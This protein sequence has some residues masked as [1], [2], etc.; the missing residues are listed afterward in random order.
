MKKSNLF[1]NKTN[2]D[3]I[4]TE[5]Y[6]FY[7]CEDALSKHSSMEF[8]DLYNLVS[9]FYIDSKINF[10]AFKNLISKNF[11]MKRTRVFPNNNLYFDDNVL[12]KVEDKIN[13]INSDNDE[14]EISYF[15]S[16]PLLLNKLDKYNIRYVKD[17]KK[18][19]AKTLLNG[20]GV[21]I[22]LFETLEKIQLPY[23]DYCRSYVQAAIA[24]V[25]DERTSQIL[26]ERNGYFL[27][28]QK[29]LEEVG[30][31]FGITRER[32]RQIEKKGLEKLELVS[33][34]VSVEINYIFKKLFESFDYEFVSSD[35]LLNYLDN[36]AL[37][38]SFMLIL[39]S[40]AV[41]YVYD[42]KYC[43]IYN[44]NL[45]KIEDV[46]KIILNKF[47]DFIPAEIYDSCSKL[48]KI[49]INQNYSLLRNK[50]IYKKKSL[51]LSAL[52][53]E[54]IAEAFPN[55]YRY[56]NE[57][58]YELFKK[59]YKE[60]F[61]DESEALSFVSLRGLL[62]RGEFCQID[63]GKV[64]ARR[65]AVKIDD[66][67]IAEI[68]NYISSFEDVAYY[69][70]VYEKFKKQLIGYGVLN[71]YYLKGIIDPY[72]PKEYI[73]KRDYIS[74][75]EEFIS[76][77]E[78]INKEI[79]KYKGA[80]SI[81]D[82]KNKYPGV[83]DYVFQF[84]IT[85]RND[86]VWLSGRSFILIKNIAVSDELKN[87]LIEELE[88]L[89]GYLDSKFVSSGKLFTRM[90]IMHEDLMNTISI[91]NN[92]HRLISLVNIILNDNYTVIREYI[93]KGNSNEDIT[94][95]SL[96]E[97]YI[98]DKKQFTSGDIKDY[99]EKM[100][101][102]GLYSFQDFMIDNSDCFIQIEKDKCV[103]KEYVVLNEN[104]LESI[105]K[106]IDYYLNSFGDIYTEKYNSYSRFPVLN[107]VWNKYLL[108]G[109][110]RCY[111]DDIYEIEYTENIST[112]TDYI[113]RRIK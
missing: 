38:E 32:I 35:Y 68:L 1:F 76:S 100:S 2:I 4:H 58:D 15:V 60:K 70:S 22:I 11:R 91:I 34:N 88:Y 3:N 41:N 62:A 27:D 89:F 52:A 31:L 94:A 55:G 40:G 17:I 77:N 48:E 13:T 111:F 84:A 67:L 6:C 112:K 83:K 81:E 72:L 50:D 29:T 23:I 97:D 49:V 92:K 85:D 86:V 33:Q 101:I 43:L 28:N 105:K 74:T 51:S 39:N 57:N 93:T 98:S 7:L 46:I 16:N 87:T 61:G 107:F 65:L 24:G 44:S 82:L 80:F 66:K 42:T 78:S 45:Y 19:D 69:T 113:I 79:E 109:V 71:R 59:K 106:E 104:Q 96:I 5:D 75:G 73:T 9:S 103:K 8:G 63:R 20:F 21:P 99:C 56:Y 10:S 95:Y 108:V 47:D 18:T 54:I 36:K 25:L 30:N 14:I 102:R 110:I 90:M 64:I 53:A 12:I 37:F 26:L